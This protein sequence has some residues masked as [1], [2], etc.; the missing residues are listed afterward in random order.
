[1][2]SEYLAVDLSLMGGTADVVVVVVVVAFL[3]VA[4]VMMD[5]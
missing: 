3:V 2:N 4:V 5:R 1:L